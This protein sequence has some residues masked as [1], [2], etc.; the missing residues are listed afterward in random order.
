MKTLTILMILGNASS[1]CGVVANL[2]GAGAF[3]I[4]LGLINIVLSGGVIY[5]LGSWLCDEGD[6]EKRKNLVKGLM[7]N[8]G[9]TVLQMIVMLWLVGSGTA[10]DVVDANAMIDDQCES[11]GLTGDACA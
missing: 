4:I 10:G 2:G 11:L 6:A 1:I 7:V 3:P 9:Q 5:L 8:V